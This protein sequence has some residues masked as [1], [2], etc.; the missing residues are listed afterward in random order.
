MEPLQIAEAAF[1]IFLP[2]PA[3]K[4]AAARKDNL[5]FVHYTGA[6]SAVGMLKNHEV[7]MR[8]P[9]TMNDF[10]EIQHGRFCLDFMWK[11]SP[12]GARLK[13]LLEGMF[14]GLIKEVEAE[15]DGSWIDLNANTF[16]ACLSEHPGGVEDEIGRLSMW[17]A[18]G[19]VALVLNPTIFMAATPKLHAY[20]YAVTYRTTEQCVDAFAEVVRRVE[21]NRE[22]LVQLG[23]PYIH[24]WVAETLR[25]TV[26]CTKHP[27]FAEEREW[28]IIYRAGADPN[29]LIEEEVEVIRGTAQPVAKLRFKPYA[30]DPELAGLQVR[31]LV[32]R[33]IIGPTQYPLAMYDAF[34][35]L[36]QKAGVEENQAAGR[37][38][39]SNIPLRV[40]M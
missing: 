31:D 8:K 3:A 5:R 4:R 37:V 16:L 24:W 15:F 27:G 28:R 17:R 23:K 12:V 29:P 2:E 6:D 40:P 18:Y 25:N 22:F 34:R 11:N 14:P 7:W 26:L 35:K 19:S 36:L 20:S 9:S 30:D 32:E 13:E 38:K 21:A 39:I 1:A 33:I 10:S